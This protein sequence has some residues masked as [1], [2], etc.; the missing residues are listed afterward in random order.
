M[1]LA[2]LRAPAL[3]LRG[4]PSG[5]ASDRR[6]ASRSVDTTES[7]SQKRNQVTRSPLEI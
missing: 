6:G 5:T 3:P 2:P 4:I 7:K 1:I